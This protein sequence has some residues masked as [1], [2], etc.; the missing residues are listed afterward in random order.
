[1]LWLL[2]AALGWTGVVWRATRP[3][4]SLLKRPVVDGRATDAHSLRCLLVLAVVAT[5]YPAEVRSWLDALIDAPGLT[6]AITHSLL[7]VGAWQLAA[8]VALARDPALAEWGMGF[9]VRRVVPAVSL[10]AP[11]VLLTAVAV[12]G[13]LSDLEQPWETPSAAWVFWTT[14]LAAFAAATGIATVASLR[15]A[16][17]DP[18]SRAGA[19]PVAAAAAAGLVYV[20][21]K[22]SALLLGIA[23]GEP[24]SP[25]LLRA[26]IAATVAVMAAGALTAA[27]LSWSVTHRA[28][29]DRR[30]ARQELAELRDQ[31]AG[32]SPAWG[33]PG[34]AD[35]PAAAAL[36]LLDALSAMGTAAPPTLWEECLAAGGGDEATAIAVWADRA[37]ALARDGADGGQAPLATLPPFAG[38]EP[39]EIVGLLR[40]VAQV[41]A[42]AVAEASARMENKEILA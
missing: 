15:V 21:L 29:L 11:C 36:D 2:V 16:A 8:A 27:V 18:E 40:R 6:S 34:A 41:P 12:G 10:A 3:G 33:D 14:W 24:S 1:M 22:A 30:R 37:S 42:A 17:A 25:P 35:E 32:H 23:A 7:V 28:A 13:P 20:P 26:A 38:L 4:Q 19:I 9:F 5:I 39:D 31:W